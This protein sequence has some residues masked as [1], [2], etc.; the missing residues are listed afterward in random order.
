MWNECDGL[1]IE[2]VAESSQGSIVD[3]H[4][5]H[6]SAPDVGILNLESARKGYK[7]EPVFRIMT[8]MC[9]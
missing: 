2:H 9:K 8:A 3:W 6:E 7:T 5:Q 1:P 4:T